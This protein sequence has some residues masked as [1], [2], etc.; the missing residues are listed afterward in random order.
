MAK[1]CKFKYFSI[2]RNDFSH[3]LNSVVSL[4]AGNFLN[5]LKALKIK[6]IYI[7]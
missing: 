7:I 3:D 2:S 1:V 4:I 6:K 5:V